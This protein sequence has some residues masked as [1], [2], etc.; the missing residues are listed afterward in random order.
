M[1]TP[2]KVSKMID[3][4]VLANGF[5]P[6]TLA[7]EAAL[8]AKG[9][10]VVFGMTIDNAGIT[11]VSDPVRHA[12]FKVTPHGKVYLYAGLPGTSGNNSSNNVSLT[13]ARFNTPRG[14]A[15]DAQGN[16]Y[17]ADSGNNQI[18]KIT[19]DG[20]VTLIAG[21]PAGTSGYVNGTAS[22]FNTP[23]DIAID[24]SN[25]I[26][27]ADTGNHAIRKIKS[28]VKNTITI[29]GTN[30][31]GDVLG[32][33]GTAR[34]SSPRSIAVDASGTCYIADTGNYKVKKM[35]VD[36]TVTLLAGST[37]GDSTGKFLDS[38]TIAVDRS[39]NLYVVDMDKTIGPRLVKINYNGDMFV[40]KRFK[41]DCVTS[42][43]Y[44]C[45]ADINRSGVIEILDSVYTDTYYS[46]DSSASSYS[47]SSSSESSGSSGSSDSSLSSSESSDSSLSS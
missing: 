30:S 1:G 4:Y 39:C 8:L 5:E 34:F 10:Y 38:F 7:G 19:P 42:R 23:W 33:G 20:L 16:I 12:I 40:M 37:R 47:S 15:A 2:N 26:Y 22:R 21:D 43:M 13:A 18:R 29:A 31:S 24:A 3:G 36:G 28:G 27:V 25:T 17:V 44:V 9:S 41:T 6:V 11:Y 45:A 35:N 46:S 14:L 32:A